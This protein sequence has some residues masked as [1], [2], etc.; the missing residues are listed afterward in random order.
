[1]RITGGL[2]DFHED[3]VRGLGVH[4]GYAHAVGPLARR[5]I[6]ELHALFFQ[7]GH[8][9]VDIVNL[10][11]YVM[12]T[13]AAFF[14][15]LLDGRGPRHI[16]QEL[17]GTVTHGDESD[18]HALK[19]LGVGELERQPVREEFER[20]V[21]VFYGDSQMSDSFDFHEAAFP[22]TW[23]PTLLAGRRFCFRS[24]GR[25]TRPGVGFRLSGRCGLLAAVCA[26]TRILARVVGN[27]PAGPLEVEAAV[28]DKLA[29]LAGA[30][31]ARLKRFIGNPL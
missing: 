16:L 26:G 6:D 11:R 14:H 30:L 5:L 24:L 22:R 2:T 4:E 18:T 28:G 19:I 27:V 1:M 29:K 8:R 10:K 21:Q 31:T 23:N 12:Y 20:L 25:R 3:A 7:F 13:F 9:L 15:E 17:N